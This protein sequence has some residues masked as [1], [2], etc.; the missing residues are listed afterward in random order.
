M[1][2]AGMSIFSINDSVILKFRLTL[3]LK[4]IYINKNK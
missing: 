1:C 2:G 3:E 4:I